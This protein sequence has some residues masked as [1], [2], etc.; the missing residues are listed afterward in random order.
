LDALVAI[1][2]AFV[3]IRVLLL[4]ALA[5]SYE[6]PG[7]TFWLSPLADPLASLRV[8]VSTLRRPQRV[9]RPPVLRADR[10]QAPAVPVARRTSA[11]RSR[12]SR[13][14]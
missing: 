5:G 10:T 7:P 6:R 13:R 4:G 2:G 8:L 14:S 3:L 1:N 11:R 9:A 12:R